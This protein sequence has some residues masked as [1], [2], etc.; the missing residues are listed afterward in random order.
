MLLDESLVWCD[1]VEREG[2]GLILLLLFELLLVENE[3][4]NWDPIDVIEG[5][6]LN[7]I[8]EL[9]GVGW[10]TEINAKHANKA[11]IKWWSTTGRMST[12]CNPG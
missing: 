9:E 11:I 6:F 8:E 7:T 12:C 1:A 4:N 3:G 2:D 10:T 5:D